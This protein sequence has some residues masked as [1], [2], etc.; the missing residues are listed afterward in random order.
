M[1]LSNNFW[2]DDEYLS[3]EINQI[4][5][6]LPAVNLL[7]LK[8][9]HVSG[10]RLVVNKSMR[11]RI[12]LPTMYESWTAPR[13]N[14]LQIEYS[15]EFP[16]IRGDPQKDLMI[17][18]T[19]GTSSYYHL[20][21]DHI[22]P[23]W[24]TREYLRHFHGIMAGAVDYYRISKNGYPTE[25][26]TAEGIFRYFFKTSFVHNV[27]D[28]Y[29]NVLYGYFY[30]YRPY[31]GPNYPYALY[32]NYRKWL[33]KFREKYCILSDG[34]QP[35]PILVPFR[36]NRT[37]EYVDRFVQKYSH[38]INF[39]PVDFGNLTIGEQIRISGSARGILGCEG[40]AFANSIFMRENSCVIPV[41]NERDRLMFHSSL[42]SYIGH[43]FKS[44]YI[45]SNAIPS[46]TDEDL[47]RFIDLNP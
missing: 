8:N 37:F 38:R 10:N 45:D 2:P 7:V 42:S 34:N 20:L 36:N 11:D 14:H 29:K 5:L 44:V 18:D 28:S 22:V 46:V 25:L 43:R 39:Q 17:F 9:T 19:W 32:P 4:H 40:A 1:S 16:V 24:I 47:L 23:L 21:V 13:K 26:E 3:Q 33:H 15:D 6:D 31:H 35:Q 41:A 30:S 12:E 27:A